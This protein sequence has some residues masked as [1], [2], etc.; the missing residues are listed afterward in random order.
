M[1]VIFKNTRFMFGFV[2]RLPDFMFG[3]VTRLSDFMFGFV[4]KIVS[5]PTN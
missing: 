4:T 5:L 1:K 2:T 3:F